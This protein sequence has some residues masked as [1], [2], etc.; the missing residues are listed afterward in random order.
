MFD[1]EKARLPQVYKRNDHECYLDPIRKKL[2]YITPEETVRQKVSFYLQEELQVPAE[3][4]V[5]EQHLSHYGIESKKRAD[6]VI[7]AYENEAQS[8]PIAVVECKA[9]DVPLDLKAREQMIDYC[10]SLG[11]DYAMLTN[12]WNTY[13]FHYDD[14]RK[15]YVDIEEFPKYK[16]ML[17]G[18]YKES[19][20]GELP[21][22]I[23]FVGLQKY[24]ED[25]FAVL[26]EDDYGD[27]IS[28]LTPMNIAVP[29]FNLWEG[30][31][32]TRVKMPTGD[33]GLFELIED[34]GVRML[35]YGNSSG[36]KF[37]GPYRSFMVRIGENTEIFS[38]AVSTYRTYAKPDLVKTCISVAHDDEKEAHHALQLVVDDNVLAEG[39]MVR[40]FHHGRIAIG[41]IGSGKV[42]ELRMF[43]ENRYPKIVSGN[44]FY[45]GSITNDRL[46]QLDDPEVIEVVVNM[47]SYAIVRDEYREFVKKN[48]KK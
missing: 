32:D 5:I 24:L 6:I 25:F 10:D 31:L 19:E 42:D 1:F 34:Y 4:I 3:Q 14:I 47:I 38:M 11:A 27:D 16:D 37:Y 48:K 46:W 29:V 8:V 22:R 35:T 30:L 23:P 28:K 45:L 26:D 41:N 2:I 40:F 15:R 17:K 12:G 9:P 39:N 18:K 36:G 33:Y 21:A 13:C 7:H 43:V 44:K 20:I